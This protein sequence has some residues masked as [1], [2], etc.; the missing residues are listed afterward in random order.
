[1]AMRARVCSPEHTIPSKGQKMDPGMVYFLCSCSCIGPEEVQVYVFKNISVLSSC[2]DTK[3]SE[4]AGSLWYSLTGV[5]IGSSKNCWSNCTNPSCHSMTAQRP[6]PIQKKV[7]TQSCLLENYSSSNM[8]S[9][10][11]IRK[12]PYFDRKQFY[13]SLHC[14]HH[15]Q[16]DFRLVSLHT[17][18]VHWHWDLPYCHLASWFMAAPWT[19]SLSEK[20]VLWYSQPHN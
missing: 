5:K 2:D 15:N 7:F 19:H 3:S 13:L 17:V 8:Y 12:T 10:Y 16:R 18:C 6:I 9:F 1:M 20:Q 11:R 14:S 4:T